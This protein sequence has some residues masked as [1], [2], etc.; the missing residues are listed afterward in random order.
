MRGV[1][2]ALIGWLCWL[3]IAAPAC[4]AETA[5]IPEATSLLV[6][7]A[8][9]LTESERDELL[10]RL[11]AIQD[12]GRAQIAILV[13]TGTAGAP[14]ADYAL[15]VAESWRLGRAGRDDG[16]LILVVPSA[17]AARIEVGYGLEGDIPDAR[18]SRWIDDLLPAMKSGALA[19]GLDR[20]LDQIE[21]VL[22]AAETKKQADTENY[23]FPD[24]PEWRLPFVLV[25]F[26]PFA[27]F[28]L[29]FGRWGSVASGPLL[30]FM[31]GSAAWMLWDS[32]NAGYAFAAVAL[33]L[34]F[35]WSLNDCETGQ[36][37]P[38]LRYAK[39]FGNVIA[40][41]LFFSVITLFV[42]AGMSALEPELVWGAPVFAGLLA[43]GLA[44]F[45]FP[46]K[47]ARYLMVGLRSAIHFV[48]IYIVACVAL[49]P[50]PH[51]S[52]I[53]LSAAA[54]VTVCAALGL[55]FDSR[56]TRAGNMR[57]S[58][59]FFGLAFV[60]ALPFALLALILA[61]G[62]EDLQTRLAQGAAGG[63]SI[64]AILALAARYGL[65]AAV[66]IGLGGRFGGGGAG[67]S[68]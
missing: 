27:I 41:V 9:A 22:P 65:F 39:A 62:G 48:F 17:N 1:L 45:L 43:T 44:V 33:P 26:S 31:L 15:Q 37:A 8:G 53:A 21:G 30:A 7:Q 6:D 60:I 68:D 47:P 32:T 10:S 16:L 29:F 3:G 64:A 2:Y 52:N 20:L 4:A 63:G 55:Y 5:A 35:L 19:K 40:V 18:A 25:V 67:R 13:S 54:A 46:G 38:W 24:H 42:G 34:P 56:G 14:L 12:S 58:V 11:K 61:V 57:L 59:W 51:P 36:L 66:N 23:L 50:I 28:P 49:A